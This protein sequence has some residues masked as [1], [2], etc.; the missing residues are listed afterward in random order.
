MSNPRHRRIITPTFLHRFC[1]VWAADVISKW[2]FSKTTLAAGKRLRKLEAD[3]EFYDAKVAGWWVWGVNAWIG[4]GWCSGDGP[5]KL[6][7][8]GAAGE[9]SNSGQGVNRQ[10]PHLG[11]SGQGVNRQ[12]PHLGDAGQGVRSE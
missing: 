1:F 12:L 2:R 5:W 10:L 8:A 11:N 7:E 9:A 3:P 6:A 4:S